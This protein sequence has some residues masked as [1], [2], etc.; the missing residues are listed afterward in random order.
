MAM[1]R[2]R[3]CILCHDLSSGAALTAMAAADALSGPCDVEIVGAQFE[4][5]L[6]PALADCPH[7]I[8]AFRSPRS[9]ALLARLIPLANAFDADVIVC[10]KLRFPSAALARCIQLFRHRPWVLLTDDDELALTAPGR[11]RALHRRLADPCGDLYTRLSHRWSGQAAA[12]ISTTQAMRKRYG[13]AVLP[14]N[15]S[16]AAFD[17]ARFDAEAARKR[18]GLGQRDFVVGFVGVPRDHKGVDDLVEAAH[19]A[20]L[21]NLKVL[22]APP[23][24]VEYEQA[25]RELATRSHYVQVL[26]GQS[27]A[28]VPELLAACD[29]VAIPQRRTAEAEGQLPAKLLEAM[30]MGRAVVAT[31][32]GDIE[33]VLGDG[34]LIVSPSSPTELAGAL[35]SLAADPARRAGL[36]RRAR[37]RY[38]RRLSLQAWAPTFLRVVQDAAL[39]R[40]QQHDDDDPYAE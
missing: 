35:R 40:P 12:C 8:H 30:A 14:V 6:W 28:R 25:C 39:G 37:Q 23:I 13:G 7:R 33:A 38:E 26:E 2:L 36:G 9:P 1:D 20:A 18:L 22:I 24:G 5:T 17:P 27:S 29:A 10:C 15:R 34:G 11:R 32:V 4:D 3:V 16:L 19:M 21:P 31:R